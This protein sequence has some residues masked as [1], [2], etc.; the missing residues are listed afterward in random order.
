MKILRQTDR[1][2]EVH[3]S[4]RTGVLLGL[5]VLALGATMVWIGWRNQ[6]VIPLAAGVFCSV[7]GIGSLWI[8]R[9][10]HHLLDADRGTATVTSRSVFGGTHR[11]TVTVFELAQIADVELEERRSTTRA[12]RR[13]RRHPTWRLVYRFHDARREPWT[14]VRSSN[15][16]RQE[17][18]QAAARLVLDAWRS[19]HTRTA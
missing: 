3:V 12:R 8:A 11:S 1:S 15:R 13:G 5:A 6:G 7:M 18:C 16:G 9:D 2:L 4:G 17:E 10:I 14:D 19:R